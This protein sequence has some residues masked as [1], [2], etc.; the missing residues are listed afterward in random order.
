MFCPN[1]ATYN[2]DPDADTAVTQDITVDTERG[3]IRVWTAS[4][5]ID[6][7]LAF[8]ETATADSIPIHG[9]NNVEYFKVPAGTTYVSIYATSDANPMNITVGEEV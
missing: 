7:F 3:A 8:N 2:I 4:G 5:S 1:G 9:N 6:L